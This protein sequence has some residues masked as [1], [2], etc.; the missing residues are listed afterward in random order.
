[1]Q[2]AARLYFD[3]ESRS[4]IGGTCAGFDR[5]EASKI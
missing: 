2:K 3:V 1:V 4:R 5:A